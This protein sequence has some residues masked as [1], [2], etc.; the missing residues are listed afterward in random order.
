VSAGTAVV[1]VGGHALGGAGVQVVPEPSSTV[2]SAEPLAGGLASRKRSAS[3]YT[4][5]ALAVK[6]VVPL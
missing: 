5:S 6:D 3:Q 4:P 1:V 2:R